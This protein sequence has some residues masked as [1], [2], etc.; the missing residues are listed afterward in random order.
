M[1]KEIE[2]LT[3]FDTSEFD[4]AVEGMQRKLREVYRPGENTGATRQTAQRLEQIGLGGHLSKPT[5]DAFNK[6]MASSRRDMDQI[7]AKEAS[8]QEKLAKY[9]A[10]REEKLKGLKKIQDE[11]VKGSEQ[12]LAVKEKISRMEENLYRQRENYKQRDQVINQGLDAREKLQPKGIAGAVSRYKEGGLNG[13]FGGGAGMLRAAGGMMGGIGTALGVGADVNDYF[14][15][16]ALRTKVNTGSAMEGTIGRTIGD[17]ATPYG[18]AWTGERT[19]ALEDASKID[20]STRLSDKLRFA[21]GS[22]LMAG[23][24]AVAGGTAGLGAVVGGA[25]AAGGVYQQFGNSRMRDLS[26]SAYLKGGG[27]LVNNMTGGHNF[28]FGNWLKGK[29]DQQMQAYNSQMAKDFAE[30]FQASLD[31]EQKT[32]PL[33][34]LAAQSYGENLSG[35]LQSQRAMGLDYNSFHGQ[36]GYREK[37]INA[38]F[39]DQMASGMSNEILGAGGSTRMARDSVFGLNMQRNM[40]MTNSGQVLGTLSSGIGDNASTRQATIKILAE[41]MRQGL[42]DSEF[43]EENRKFTQAAA[44]IISKSG[45]ATGADFERLSKGFGEFLPEKTTK[46][47]EAAKTAYDEFQEVSSSTTGARGV[48]RAAGFMKDKNLSKLSTIEKQALM[49]V[50]DQDLNENNMLVKGLADKYGIPVSDFKQSV[51]NV[52]EGSFSRFKE[53]DEIRDRLKKKQVDIGRAY[54]DDKYWKGLDQDS[55]NDITEMFSYQTTELGYKG[56][57]ES[58]ARAQRQV[59]KPMEDPTGQGVRESLTEEKLQ[60][61]E[62]GKV[63]DD[64]VRNMAE[65]SR[66]VLTSFQTFSKEMIPTVDVIKQFNTAIQGAITSMKTMSTKDQ[67]KMNSSLSEILGVQKP[68]NKNQTQAR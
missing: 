27:E 54:T 13:M 40:N 21:S 39:T 33:K 23:G 32:N 3:K 2:F 18:Q 67:D 47:L 14:A 46:G 30:N 38:G 31:A 24:A 63:E 19:K 6:S 1:R 16:T 57:R 35:Y 50:P 42:N 59:G 9:I 53:H 61:K 28:G 17:M 60:Y 12:E 64:T 49:Q 11:M 48:M 25:A 36:G 55:K 45:A 66:L 20:K 4:R 15:R 51:Q 68:N 7:I 5:M 8:G 65:S 37:A 29:G 58:V 52:N 44:E 41:G 43:T 22:A 34:K 62:T 56:Q 26:S 10:K